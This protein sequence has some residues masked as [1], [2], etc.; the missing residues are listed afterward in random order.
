MYTN[1]AKKLW[2]FNIAVN[3]QGWSKI[4]IHVDMYVSEDILIFFFKDKYT[5]W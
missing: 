5:K 1:G 4:K 3:I 2:D